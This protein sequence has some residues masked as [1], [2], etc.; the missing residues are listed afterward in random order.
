MDISGEFVEFALLGQDWVLWLLVGLS[1]ISVGVMIE[2]GIFF[3]RQRFDAEAFERDVRKALAG[4]DTG[5]LEDRYGRSPAMAVTVALTGVRERALGVDAVAEAMNGAK[6]RA[7][8]EQEQNL[9]VLGTLGNNAP[10]IGLFGTV[11]G[12]IAAFQ[13]L[14][15]RPGDVIDAVMSDVSRALVATAVGI[16][17]AI[18][19]VVAFNLYQ[20]RV[21]AEVGRTDALAHLILAQVHAGAGGKGGGRAGEPEVA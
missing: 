17:V 2:R 21:R 13:H 18:P 11:L 19:A 14:S 15:D 10:F 3:R 6:T 9:V 12:I 1:V 5:A 7:R 20:R 8:Q 4:G 16:L